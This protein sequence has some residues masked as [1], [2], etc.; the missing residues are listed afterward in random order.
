MP[1]KGILLDLDN[2]LYD[3]ET[4]HKPALAAAVQYLSGA[5]GFEPGTIGDAYGKAR[6]QINQQL[7]GQ[8]ASHSRLLYFQRVHELL[9]LPG[10][11]TV[12]EAE[13]TYWRTF[14]ECMSLRPGVTEFLD[15]LGNAV[16]VGI[17]SDL[18]AQIQFRKLVKLKLERRFKA[19]VTSEE[20]GAEKPRPEIFQ[21]ALAK[22]G[23]TSGAACVIGDSWERDIIGGVQLGMHCYWLTPELSSASASGAS[24]AELDG[25]INSLPPD[26]GKLV[27][28]VCSFDELSR[29]ISAQMAQ[30]VQ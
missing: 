7:S 6:A 4:A 26:A 11:E 8:A 21:I 29:L 15:S 9:D 14:L 30:G 19:V 1:L 28:R 3:Y 23:I 17:I 12:L 10:Y 18:T 27:V 22:L 24:Q 16:V 2:T 20:S 5:T 13:E 25:R